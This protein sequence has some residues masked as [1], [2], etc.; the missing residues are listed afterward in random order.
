MNF[1]QHDMRVGNATH[2]MSTGNR[3]RTVP[4]DVRLS[5][6]G[7]LVAVPE[8]KVGRRTVLHEQ[9][10]VCRDTY[11]AYTGHVKFCVSVGLSGFIR[12]RKVEKSEH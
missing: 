4:P 12:F 5:Y 6:A 7:L 3:D 1:V 9:C 8:H 2:D 10:T 11:T